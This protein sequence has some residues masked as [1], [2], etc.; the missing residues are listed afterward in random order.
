MK[1]PDFAEICEVLYKHF[2][3][4]SKSGY[5]YTCLQAMGDQGQENLQSEAPSFSNIVEID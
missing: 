2:G 3:T 1:E 5:E 4:P